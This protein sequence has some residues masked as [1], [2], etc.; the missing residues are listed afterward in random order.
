[1]TQDDGL[2]AYFNAAR[3]TAPAPS[4]ALLERIAQDAIAAQAP[5]PALAPPPD[6]PQPGWL[7]QLW[8]GLG[9]WPAFGGLATA[10]MAGVWIGVYPPSTVAFAAE[11]YFGSESDAYII[12]LSP[13]GAFDLA[14]E[15]L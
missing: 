1:M 2:E 12:D 9:G 11:S 13:D 14:E 3:T 10:T 5:A 6:A 15:A 4:A 7:S 8:Q